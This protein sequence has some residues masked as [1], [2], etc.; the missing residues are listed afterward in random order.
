M[1][2]VTFVDGGRSRAGF[3][4]G[5]E[6]VAAE[7][8][9]PSLPH[10]MRELLSV[11]PQLGQRFTERP[12]NTASIPLD[13]ATLLPAIPNPEKIICI[14]LNY[15]DHAKESGS[16][17]PE[18]PVVFNK[19]LS[20]LRGNGDPIELPTASDSVDYEAELVVVI[21]KEGKN[22][23][24]SDAMDYVAGYTCGH[25]VSARDWQKNKPGGQWLCGKTFDTFAPIGPHIVS[26]DEI[27]DPHD[28]RIQLRLNGETMQ[29]SSTKQLI[30]NV[31]Q[32]ISYISQVCTFRPG[33]L[34]FTG[35]P[36]GVGA[37]RKPPVFLQPGDVAEV[38]IDGIGLLTN[39]VVQGK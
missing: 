20:A 15:A 32:L 35:T 23:S 8:L 11:L 39:P 36:P 37:A 17:I 13:D 4:F 18:E 10:T 9:D 25:D 2:L 30:F 26:A 21:G 29:D 28:L 5:S 34:I 14:G 33:D 16:A 7:D 31:P 12:R 19:F 6:I 38:E 27:P 1:K 3:V 22:I 24:E